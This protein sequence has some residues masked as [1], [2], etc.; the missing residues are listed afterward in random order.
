MAKLKRRK[1][2]TKRVKVTKKGKVKTAKAFK[3]HLLTSK[4]RKRKRHLKQ[5]NTLT[6]TAAAKIRTMVA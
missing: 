6:K 3:G 1:A 2:V 4:N 5:K